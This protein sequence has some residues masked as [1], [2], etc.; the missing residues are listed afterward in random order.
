MNVLPSAAFS[1]TVR[2]LLNQTEKYA[3]R[4]ETSER[5][6]IHAVVRGG[7]SFMMERF[8]CKTLSARIR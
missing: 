2:A 7:F 5:A 1:C 4:C 8:S 6:L 3:V